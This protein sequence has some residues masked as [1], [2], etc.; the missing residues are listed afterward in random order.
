MEKENRT[1]DSGA[2]LHGDGRLVEEP[3]GRR[4]DHVRKGN[5]LHVL[6]S[7]NGNIVWLAIE[8]TA[9]D[10]R[11]IG[12][13]WQ[14]SPT[15]LLDKVEQSDDEAMSVRQWKFCGISFGEGSF[16]TNWQPLKMKCW[17]IFYASMTI[18]LAVISTR[19]LLSPQKKQDFRPRSN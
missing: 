6:N 10:I 11:A 9:D 8:M 2:G 15:K 19:L 17:G 14:S 16:A 4:S 3:V 7:D 5:N 12:F 13:V 1:A 18:P